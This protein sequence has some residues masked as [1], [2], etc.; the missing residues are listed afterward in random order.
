MPERAAEVA[1]LIG[2]VSRNGVMMI[3]HYIHLVQHE[4]EVFSEQMI[5]RRSLERL[6]RLTVNAMTSFIGPLPLLFRAGQTGK[7][8]IHPLALVVIGGMLTSTILHQLVPPALL[9]NLVVE[10]T[11]TRQVRR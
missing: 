5:V 7:E 11:S 8:I 6:T 4:S 1:A 10:S 3:L 9:F 2:V